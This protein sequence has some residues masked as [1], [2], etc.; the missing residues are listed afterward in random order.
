MSSELSKLLL[1][2]IELTNIETCI[3]CVKIF[4]LNLFGNKEKDLKTALNKGELYDK[5]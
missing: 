3:K 5:T 2:M 1:A 4:L